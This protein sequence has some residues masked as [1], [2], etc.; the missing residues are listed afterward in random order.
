[1]WGRNHG[2]IADRSLPHRHA[3]STEV[4]LEVFQDLVAQLVL[5]KQVAEDKDRGLTRD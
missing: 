5:L 1:M 2:G 3:L 4:K